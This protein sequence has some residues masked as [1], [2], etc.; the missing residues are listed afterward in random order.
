MDGVFSR[1][2]YGKKDNPIEWLSQ[3]AYPRLHPSKKSLYSI[4]YQ[5]YGLMKESWAQKVRI[6]YALQTSGKS[7]FVSLL[8]KIQ[9]AGTVL[10]YI[11]GGGASKLQVLDAGITYLYLTHFA[12]HKRFFPKSNTKFQKIYTQP[13]QQ[14]SILK[15]DNRTRFTYTWIYRFFSTNSKGFKSKFLASLLNIKEIELCYSYKI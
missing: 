12:N 13:P 4:D 11:P 8:K 14:T 10:W 9:T 3:F 1:L 6:S 15:H 7:L 2:S 5:K